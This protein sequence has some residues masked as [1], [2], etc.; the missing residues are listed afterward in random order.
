VQLADAL[1]ENGIVT[2]AAR[3]RADEMV[4]LAPEWKTIMPGRS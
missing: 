4:S 2:E 1:Q 3:L